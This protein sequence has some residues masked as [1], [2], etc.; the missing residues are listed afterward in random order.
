[1][2]EQYTQ[3]AAMTGLVLI[4]IGLVLLVSITTIAIVL[5]KKVMKGL[6]EPVAQIEAAVKQLR[7]VPIS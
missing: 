3:E 2:G 6:T 5:S 7:V 4:L 1:M